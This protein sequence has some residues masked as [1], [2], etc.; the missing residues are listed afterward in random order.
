MVEVSIEVSS[1]AARFHVAVRAES[2]Q[3]A[4]NLWQR[5]TPAGFA[6]GSYRSLPKVSS[7]TTPLL[8]RR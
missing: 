6:D 1:G 8:E 2:V 3:R 7:W 5:V 4:T